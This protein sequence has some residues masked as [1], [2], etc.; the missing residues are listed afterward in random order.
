MK[1][2]LSFHQVS[3]KDVIVSIKL[4]YFFEFRQ[5]FQE[6]FTSEKNHN[7]HKKFLPFTFFYKNNRLC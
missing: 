3:Q 6:K 5:E 2:Y 7:F 1:K 4:E